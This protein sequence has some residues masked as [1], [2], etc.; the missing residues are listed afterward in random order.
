M[1][2]L[3]IASLYVLIY[4]QTDKDVCAMNT[5]IYIY[6]FAITHHLLP[7]YLRIIA[8]PFTCA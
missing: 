1:H 7:V 3:V 8:R 5:Y 4:A 6:I 2:I